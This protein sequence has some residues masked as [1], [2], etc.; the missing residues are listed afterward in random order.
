M[1]ESAKYS[2]ELDKV[3]RLTGKSRK[4]LEAEMRQKNSDIRRQVAM[5]NMTS[6]QQIA[7]AANLEVAGAKS[8]E[9]EAALLDMADGIANDPVN[10]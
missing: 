2:L 6:D 5:A 7:F 3:A 1:H 4:D 10:G 8:K 9:F